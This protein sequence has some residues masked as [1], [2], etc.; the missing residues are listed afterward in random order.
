[1]LSCKQ[2]NLTQTASWKQVVQTCWCLPACV[3]ACVQEDAAVLAR[4]EEERRRHE[5]H[6]KKLQDELEAK[7]EAERRWEGC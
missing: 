2:Q 6:L 7:K 5:A 1:M 3:R 4:E